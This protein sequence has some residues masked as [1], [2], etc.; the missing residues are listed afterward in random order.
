MNNLDRPEN[1]TIS[2]PKPGTGHIA[3]KAPDRHIFFLSGQSIG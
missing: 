2:G 1:P 3:A